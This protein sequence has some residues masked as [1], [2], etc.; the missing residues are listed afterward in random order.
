VAVGDEGL[1]AVEDV[2]VA[3]LDGGGAGAAGVGA[4]AGLGEPHAPSHSPLASAGCTSL[5]RFVAGEEDV[6][7]AE[8]VVRG[9]DDADRAVDAESS[10]MAST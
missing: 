2:A 3:L 5:L 4:G 6:V 8:R 7:G 10:S 1:V 9:D